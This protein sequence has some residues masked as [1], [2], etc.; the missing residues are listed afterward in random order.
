VPKLHLT[1]TLACALALLAVPAVARAE[2]VV[3]AADN[4]PESSP[5]QGERFYDTMVE[6]GL[7]ENRLSV[8]WDAL[9]PAR[10]DRQAA[11]EQAVALA[12]A[13]GIRITFSV[14]PGRAR[15]ITGSRP[16]GAQFAAFL[17][18]LARTYPQ[19]K[20]FIV[21]NEPN[22]ANFWQPQFNPNGT[23]AA[24]SSYSTLLAAS[25]DA[26]K[27]VDRQITV[28]GLA[29]GARG[30]DNARARSN[31][32]I[33]PVRCIRDVGRAYRLSR[34]A[35]PLMDEISIHPYPQNM[36]DSLETGYRWPN[37]GVPNL[38]R[39]KQAVWDAFNG[40][41]QPTFQE[42]GAPLRTMKFR[43]NE[44]GWQVAIPPGSQSA[45]YGRETVAVT[46]DGN[47]AAIY[48]N[49]I[50]YLA[51]DASVR[52]LLF[53]NMVD[54]PDLDRWQSGLLR[55][56]WTL[57]PSYNIV[58]GAIGARATRCNRRPVVWRHALNVV[59]AK[60]KFPDAKRPRRQRETAWTFKARAEE[61]ATF[62]A[63]LFPAKKQGVLP[64]AA[65]ARITRNLRGARVRGAVLKGRGKIVGGWARIVRL[66]KKRLKPGYYAFGIRLAAETNPVRTTTLV[67]GA[68]KVGEPKA[69]TRAKKKTSQ[70]A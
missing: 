23:G 68:F 70:G 40:T 60:V 30:N 57:R 2:L 31:Q 56:D 34:R 42:P 61:G 45:Y 47:Q 8:T 59:D 25:Y 22:K 11:L 32:S 12:T 58:K 4:R 15:A 67:G 19:V 3:G 13:R 5:E 6:V 52:S 66:P 43:L 1:V 53:F 38:A 39:I 69:K 62:T 26:L 27:S 37:A 10:I 16:A 33:S 21:G 50:P 29:V 54:E 36:S 64:A 18:Q 35:R 24:C 28:I 55:A 17:A 20:D 48:G 14:Y 65:R 41:A 9:E 63:A 7:K 46:D 49:L 44:V 51:C